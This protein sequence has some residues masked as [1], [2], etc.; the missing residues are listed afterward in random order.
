MSNV[1]GVD[2]LRPEPVRKI[3]SD[4]KFDAGTG[5]SSGK[6]K[7][8]GA[9]SAVPQKETGKRHLKLGGGKLN[10]SKVRSKF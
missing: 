10:E 3:K 2:G 9:D 5:G 4:V 7:L 6:G 8:F 1:F